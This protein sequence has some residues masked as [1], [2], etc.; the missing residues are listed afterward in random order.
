[1]GGLGV[2]GEAASLPAFDFVCLSFDFVCVFVFGLSRLRV[3]GLEFRVYG[4]G[5]QGV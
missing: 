3:W 4:S 1:M 2:A 5:F